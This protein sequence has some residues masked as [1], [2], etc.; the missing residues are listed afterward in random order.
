MEEDLE[1]Y[2]SDFIDDSEL[3]EAYYA[4][5]ASKRAKTVH[6]GFFA[7]SGEV[8]TESLASDRPP[9]GDGGGGQGGRGDRGGDDSATAVR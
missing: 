9:L 3:V 4:K 1:G 5:E 2:E 8:E 6:T 7:H